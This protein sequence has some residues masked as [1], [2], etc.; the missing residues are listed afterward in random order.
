MVLGAKESILC[1]NKTNRWLRIIRRITGRAHTHALAHS[2]K[3]EHAQA[4]TYMHINKNRRRG[5]ASL[6][7]STQSSP[8]KSIAFY[9]E[10]IDFVMF[11]AE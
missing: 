2:I 11:D 3:H 1:D 7:L 9:E 4:H 5:I 8:I 6:S 10:N